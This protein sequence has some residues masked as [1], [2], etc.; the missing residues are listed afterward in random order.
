MRTFYHTYCIAVLSD[1]LSPTIT[2]DA[3][4]RRNV[5][6]GLVPLE[7]ENAKTLERLLLETDE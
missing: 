2:K 7:P 4:W 3:L 1:T 6:T 5:R